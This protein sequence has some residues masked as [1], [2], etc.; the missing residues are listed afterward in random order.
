MRSIAVDGDGLVGK[1]GLHKARKHHSVATGLAW[2][3]GVKEADGGDLEALGC[4]ERVC[5]CFFERFGI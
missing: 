5:D 2:A 3:D 4:V 1:G